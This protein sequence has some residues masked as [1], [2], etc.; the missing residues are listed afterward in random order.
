M[1]PEPEPSSL[2]TLSSLKSNTVGFLPPV[3]D[4]ISAP[5]TK[6]PMTIEW[7]VKTV[8][9][10]RDLLNQVPRANWMQSW[11]Y[12]KAAHRR[13]YKSTKLGVIRQDGADIGCVAIQEIRLGAIRMININRGPLWFREDVDLADWS[14]FAKLLRNTYPRHWLQRL[15]WMP[16]LKYSTE[17]LMAIT[18][19]G[20]R[21]TPQTYHTS[22]L[23]LRKSEEDLRKSL[24]L[25]WR[26]NLSRFE[27]SGAQIHIDNSNVDLLPFIREYQKHKLQKGYAG[28]T[29]DFLK[30]E[31]LAA[32]PFSDTSLLWAIDE[33]TAVAGIMLVLH[34]K[35]ASYRMGWNTETGRKLNSHYG[36]LWRAVTAL[37]DR[38]IE[39]FDL[40]GLL[41]KEAPHLTHFKTGMKG[42]HI[43]L[44]GVFR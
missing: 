30:E 18:D 24:R 33:G 41:P 14:K 31:F 7:S 28:P 27:R 3:K 37:R 44:V 29:A 10:W 4:I 9:E 43:Q 39:S 40:G 32:H 38:G 13:D 17:A 22:W 11:S 2:P 26:R 36:L 12:A 25:K 19:A 1:K 42:D 35:S 15:R 16:E 8:G 5:I 20:F 21:Q 23:D 34:G 6:T